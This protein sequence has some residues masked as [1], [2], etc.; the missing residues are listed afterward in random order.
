MDATEVVE[1][2]QAGLAY[3]YETCGNLNSYSQDR[4]FS[5]LR[6]QTI[7][8]SYPGDSGSGYTLYTENGEK[9]G[10]MVD[11]VR[12][13][14]LDHAFQLV[15]VEITQDSR[16]AVRTAFSSGSSFSACVHAVA[17][18]QTDMCIGNFWV[19]NDRMLMAASFTSPVYTDEFRLVVPVGGAKPSIWSRLVQPFVATFSPAAWFYMFVLAAY[20]SMA[21]LFVEGAD[22]GDGTDHVIANCKTTTDNPLATSRSGS[23][24]EEKMQASYNSAYY[25]I[26]GALSGSP[27]HEARTAGGRMVLAGFAVFC[28][29]FI[30]SFTASTAATLIDVQQTNTVIRSL[31]D[32]PD[33]A[34]LC[35]LQSLAS[36]FQLRYPQ[37]TGR[38]ESFSDQVAAMEA[39]DA[40]KCAGAVLMQDS[41]NNIVAGKEE[42]YTG[43]PCK[44]A[45]VDVS[46]LTAENA[47]PISDEL[48]QAMSYVVAR[49]VAAN[50]YGQLAQL[51]RNKR[52]IVKRDSCHGV[53]QS[54]GSQS[55]S[56]LDAFHMLAPFSICFVC[57]TAGLLM[58]WGAV[59]AAN[60]SASTAGFFLGFCVLFTVG[61]CASLAWELASG[62][63]IDEVS[64]E[65][66][67]NAF[68]MGCLGG[69]LNLIRRARG[70]SEDTDDAI[71]A[72]DT[73]DP[74]S[75]A[76]GDKSWAKTEDFSGALD[77]MSEQVRLPAS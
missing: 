23:V 73:E 39:L 59:V 25:S 65:I 7:R 40:R 33:S 77:D 2:A 1:A 36:R 9:K 11:F 6:G 48:Q 56:K 27:A 3:S 44:Y 17:I 74:D 8:V 51:Q 38:V 49:E 24:V 16:N 32:V 68:A 71:D 18:G 54:E 53:T 66:I 26:L 30:A 70:L 22:V 35:M 41:W 42:G 52:G 60:R 75:D 14:A 28:L 61:G 29:F 15:E 69:V 64:G 21:M 37:F 67:L 47:M 46:L 62:E 50:G 4:H 10:S 34:R 5:A 43:E 13:L 76:T 63:E 72:K 55:E 57:T 31:D 12:K 58:R 19:T 45:A 20:V